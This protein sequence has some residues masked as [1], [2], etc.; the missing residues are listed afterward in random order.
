MSDVIKI[1]TGCT[2]LMNGACGSSH[3]YEVI[4]IKDDKH[5]TVRRMKATPIGQRIDQNYK[6]ESDSKGIVIDLHKTKTN[7]WKN[8]HFYNLFIVGMAIEYDATA[9][10][11]G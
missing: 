9:K 8:P 10:Y 11:L 5:I 1:G 7:K 4:K 6:L 2:C 3:A